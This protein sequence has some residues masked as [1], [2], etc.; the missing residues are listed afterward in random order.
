V[1]KPA[2]SAQESGHYEETRH[3]ASLKLTAPIE[4]GTYELRYVTGTTRS[5]LARARSKSCP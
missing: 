3:G 2:A 4:P 1:V 5:I